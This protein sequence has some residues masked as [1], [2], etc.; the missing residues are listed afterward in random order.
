M[1]T[2]NILPYRSLWTERPEI[3][4]LVNLRQEHL[5]QS[6]LAEFLQ[7]AETSLDILAAYV[8]ALGD[9][10]L[11]AT[12]NQLLHSVALHHVRAVLHAPDSLSEDLQGFARYVRTAVTRPDLRSQLGL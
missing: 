7:P 5:S 8:R 3:V 1:V 11:T 6:C 10:T 9:D 2:I 4:R 12:R